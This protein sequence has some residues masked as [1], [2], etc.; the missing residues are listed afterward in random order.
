MKKLNHMKNR[1]SIIKAWKNTFIVYKF[2]FAYFVG[3]L[4]ALRTQITQ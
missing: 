4:N 2:K 1:R 3:T